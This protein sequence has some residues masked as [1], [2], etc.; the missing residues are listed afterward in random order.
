MSSDKQTVTLQI[1]PILPANNRVPGRKQ[2]GNMSIFTH[3]L[4]ELRGDV[5]KVTC[6]LAYNK[7]NDTVLRRVH[8]HVQV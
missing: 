1:K 6:T 5:S 3:L 7:N 4:S 8:G 2:T